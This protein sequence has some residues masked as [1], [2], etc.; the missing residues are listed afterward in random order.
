MSPAA[1]RV[2]SS[3]KVLRIWAAQARSHTVTAVKQLWWELLGL[4]I[5]LTGTRPSDVM[6]AGRRAGYRALGLSMV[7]VIAIHWICARIFLTLAL[8]AQALR[9]LT[10]SSST[11]GAARFVGHLSYWEA[12]TVWAIF[13]YALELS[14][15][16]QVGT[17]SVRPAT[18][19]SGRRHGV[20]RLYGLWGRVGVAI[21]FGVLVSE[22]LVQL[23]FAPS[24]TR[25]VAANHSKENT[26]AVNTET[27]TATGAQ[28]NGLVDAKGQPTGVYAQLLNQQRQLQNNKNAARERLACEQN[29]NVSHLTNDPETTVDCASFPGTGRPGYEVAAQCQ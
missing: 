2:R 29:G 7:V 8:D 9:D 18:T 4:P 12:A 13:I 16:S 14:I 19:K 6:T 27:N 11:R 24:L 23:L 15:T 3:L 22:M 26:A 5:R 10:G 17:S 21:V 1:D 20:H 28:A 25:V